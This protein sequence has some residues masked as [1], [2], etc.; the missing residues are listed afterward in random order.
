MDFV[1]SAQSP[2]QPEAVKRINQDKNFSRTVNKTTIKLDGLQCICG[3]TV[4]YR[5]EEIMSPPGE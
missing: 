3:N 4:Q 2:E 5:L 1:S